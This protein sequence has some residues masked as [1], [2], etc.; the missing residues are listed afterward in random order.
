VQADA[1][2]AAIKT[3]RKAAF[4]ALAGRMEVSNGQERAIEQSLGRINAAV[5]GPLS[6]FACVFPVSWL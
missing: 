4:A 1:L 3:Q 6:P 5:R 2:A